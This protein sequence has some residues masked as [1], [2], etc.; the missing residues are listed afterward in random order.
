[1]KKPMMIALAI[2]I[3]ASTSAP[4]QVV[5]T[6]RTAP[7]A[8][9]GIRFDEKVEPEGDTQ[10]ESITVRNVSKDSPAQKAGMRAGDEILRVNGMAASNGKFRALAGI[11]AVGDT[12]RLRIRRDG[13]ESDVT[14]IAAPRP[15]GYGEFSRELVIAPD[16]VRHLM[17]RYLD[18]AR[19]HLDSLRLP[20][21]RVPG[22]FDFGLRVAPKLPDP[23]LWKPD[24]A[25]DVVF[26]SMQLGARSIAGAEF[27]EMDPALAQYF[28]GR[29]GLLTLRVVPETPA[30]RAGLKPGDIVLEAKDRTVQ[31]VSDL[32]AIVAANPDGMKLDIWRKGQARTLELKTRLR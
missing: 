16:S 10:R 6:K 27:S 7:A 17:L 13:R 5:Y 23:R 4:A 30:D 21:I 31:R 26:H 11:L 22:E 20:T 28:D 15:A 14:I 1:M 9:L 12:V 2:T 25:P 18:A 29:R 3:V 24:L 8:Y 32:R 19:V